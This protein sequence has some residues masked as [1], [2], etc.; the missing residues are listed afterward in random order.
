MPQACPEDAPVISSSKSK[1][2][3]S[4]PQSANT[5]VGKRVLGGARNAL[6]ARHLGEFRNLGYP[7]NEHI[8]P[9]ILAPFGPSP[10]IGVAGTSLRT[11]SLVWGSLPPAD[12]LGSKKSA[13]YGYSY[14]GSACIHV[15]ACTDCACH[16][17]AN[18]TLVL[19]TAHVMSYVHM[20]SM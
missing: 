14:G 12:R 16:A 15:A 9:V 8:K 13:I 1:I 4:S 7:R 20:R 19:C 11:T 5:P 10:D 2:F 18:A 3:N 6:A 17:S